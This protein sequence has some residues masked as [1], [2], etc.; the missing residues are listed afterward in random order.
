MHGDLPTD[1]R[2]PDIVTDKGA[3]PA[4]PVIGPKH[5]IAGQFLPLSPELIV[6][7]RFGAIKLYMWGW[8]EYNDVFLL[9][10]RHRTEFCCEIMVEG[11]IY[12]EDIVFRR[13]FLWVHNGADQDCLRKPGERAPKVPPPAVRMDFALPQKPG[14]V[15][16]R[17]SLSA[18]GS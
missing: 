7:A 6:G 5:S 2:F 12:P 16:E 9:T 18:S 1:F 17:W 3:Q 11:G 15:A 8:I 10:P 13:S 14:D 4:N